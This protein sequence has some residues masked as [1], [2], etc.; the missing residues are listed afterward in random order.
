MVLPSDVPTAYTTSFP[1]AGHRRGR[2]LGSP[3]A[4]GVHGDRPLTSAR[5]NSASGPAWLLAIPQHPV[6]VRV[7][8]ERSGIWSDLHRQRHIDGGP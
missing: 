2:P 4:V 5:T 6:K 7:G 8:V 1:P 3:Q